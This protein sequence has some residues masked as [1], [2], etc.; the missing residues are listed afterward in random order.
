[1][2]PARPQAAGPAR[3]LTCRQPLPAEAPHR[4]FCSVR[5]KLVDLGRWLNDEYKVPGEPAIGFGETPDEELGGPFAAAAGWDEPGLAWEEP[6][7]E[8]DA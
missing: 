7:D 5:C 1:M 4:P 3:C 8:Q 2:S 6:P